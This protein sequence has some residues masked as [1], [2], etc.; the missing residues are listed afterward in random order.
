MKNSLI[1]Y[2]KNLKVSVFKISEESKINY[3]QFAPYNP[4]V[5]YPEYPLS[6]QFI[7]KEKNYAYEGVREGLRLLGLDKE[8]FGKSSWNPFK[9][10]IKP[11]N[12]VLV[13]PNFVLSSHMERGNLY[14][15][16]THPSV[17]RAVVDYCFIALRGHGRIIIADAPQMD[18]DFKTLLKKTQLEKIKELYQKEKNFLIEIYDLRNFW[19]KK[20][21]E[22]PAYHSFRE[23]L[24]GDPEGSIVFNLGE[25]SEFYGLKNHHKFYGADFNRKETIRH[26]HDKIQ[27][28][29]LSK[30]VLLSDIIIS[31]PK[32]KVHKKTGVTLNAKGLV[33]INTNKNY[34]VHYTLGSPSEGGDQF[35]DALRNKEKFFIKIQ[36]W[37]F[38]KFLSRKSKIRESVYVSI[39]NFYKWFIKILRV[40]VNHSKKVLDSGNWYGNDT[41]WRM[42]VDLMKIIYFGDA[43]GKLHQT[44]QRKIFSI[45]DGI[46][47]GE[48]EGPLTPAEK[49]SGIIILGFNPI[50]ADLVAI[51]SMGFNWRKLKIYNNLLKNSYFN[52][53]IDDPDKIKLISNFEIDSLNFIPPLGWRGF[54]KTSNN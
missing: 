11:G 46:I 24:L 19:L 41:A 33:G 49:K 47:G 30:T 32:L 34:L 43:G 6:Q 48:K 38:D 21:E 31:I 7:S 29:C 20:R 28:Y 1:D 10:I 42:A 9:K 36:R 44:P 53:F 13:K 3:P 16:I 26:H 5:I 51:K 14:S 17:I 23:G 12:K 54:I 35:P 18:C 45:I 8:N 37:M 27:E 40:K 2:Y 50:A 25:K 4:S 52:F 39:H 15:I 22:G